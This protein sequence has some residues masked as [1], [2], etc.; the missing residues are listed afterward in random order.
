MRENNSSRL[1]LALS[2]FAVLHERSRRNGGGKN[3]GANFGRKEHTALRAVFVA[4]ISGYLLDN[5]AYRVGSLQ[6][7]WVVSLKSP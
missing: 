3:I 5:K 4:N 7:V 2:G 1:A 6:Q